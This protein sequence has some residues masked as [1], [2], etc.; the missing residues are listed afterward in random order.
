V[1]GAASQGSAD[2]GRT[3]LDSL[4][5]GFKEHLDALTAAG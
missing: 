3:V 5:S 2:K 4:V 1:I